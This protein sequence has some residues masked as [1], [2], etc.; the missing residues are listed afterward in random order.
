MKAATSPPKILNIGWGEMKKV[1]LIGGGG[2][3][4]SFYVVNLISVE[5][6]GGRAILETANCGL[7]NPFRPYLGSW[8]IAELAPE[9]EDLPLGHYLNLGDK[10]ADAESGGMFSTIY[11]LKIVKK[12]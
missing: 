5:D 1:A 6:H 4:N 12:L 9:L 10:I 7:P 8:Q 3:A 11:Q 2:V